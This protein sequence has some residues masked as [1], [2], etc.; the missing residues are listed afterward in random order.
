MDQKYLLGLR[1]QIYP[2]KDLQRAKDW[3]QKTLGIDPYFDEAFYVCECGS[4]DE[5][6]G[7][8][9]SR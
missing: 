4:S 1:S 8:E 5:V 7:R 6:E 9:P 3:W 2:V